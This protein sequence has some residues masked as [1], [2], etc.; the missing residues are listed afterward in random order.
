MTDIKNFKKIFLLIISIYTLS[1]NTSNLNKNNFIN[2][3]GLLDSNT[4]IK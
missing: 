2:T 4:I 1:C 3:E